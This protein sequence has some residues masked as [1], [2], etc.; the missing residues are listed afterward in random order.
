MSLSSDLDS[1]VP[2][3]LCSLLSD[4][5]F[6]TIP[7]ETDKLLVQTDASADGLGACLSVIRNGEE[8]PAALY[9]RKLTDTESR[10]AATELE[11]LAV[12]EACRQFEAYLDGKPFLLQTDHK[13]LESMHTSKLYNKRLARWA[14]KLQGFLFSVVYMPGSAN[15]NADG[16][17]RQAW[18][19]QGRQEHLLKLKMMG[20]SV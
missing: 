11:C 17:S 3:F 9:S 19:I 8:L 12:V 16:L 18:G 13:A 14:L 4:A 5:S 15:G 10:Y 1:G 6:L 7:S 20:R 2:G